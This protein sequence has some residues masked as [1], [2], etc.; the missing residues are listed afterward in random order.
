MTRHFFLFLCLN[1]AILC[2]APPCRAV[3]NPELYHVVVPVADRSDA[4]R[5]DAVQAAMKIVLVRVTGRRSAEGDSSLA[6]M[7]D[8][9][10]RYVQAYR[11]APDGQLW[12]AFDGAA[13]ERWLTQNG[14]PV[15]GSARPSTFV[16]LLLTT[17]QQNGVIATQDDKSDLK[18]LIDERAAQ[19]GIP[20]LWPTA[21][22][23]QANRLDFAAASAAPPD[24]LV[25]IARRLGAQGVLIG[26]AQNG[27]ASANVSWKLL[28]QT[29]SGEA[30]GAAEGVDLAADTY[31]S[32]F[33]AQGG[34]LPVDID[35][36]GIGSLQDY[37]QVQAYLESLSL[38]E[39]VAIV[40]LTG[41]SVRFRIGARG[42]YGPLVRT[43]ALNGI[44]EPSAAAVGVGGGAP[45]VNAA[46]QIGGSATGTVARFHLRR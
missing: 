25:S 4:G 20:L 9:A 13:I 7:V 3:G 10:D 22:D 15:W 30:E 2:A 16:W 19:R 21:S 12:V 1:C 23:L 36:D 11:Y 14:Q 6:P 26:R 32:I 17:A 29:Q 42:G 18:A 40:S 33:A 44:L 46:A 37:A 41:D 43:L 39:H 8:G 31:A 45:Q 24:L 28:F 27:G 5:G 34:V 35:V 38:V